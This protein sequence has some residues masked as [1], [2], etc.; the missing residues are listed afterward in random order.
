MKLQSEAL[1]FLFLG[2]ISG[3]EG[4]FG[5][6]ASSWEGTYAFTFS[7]KNSLQMHRG[8]WIETCYLDGRGVLK[9]NT[10]Y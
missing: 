3:D 4:V 7:S 1:E 6:F 8:G 10:R 5:W 9:L 2:G